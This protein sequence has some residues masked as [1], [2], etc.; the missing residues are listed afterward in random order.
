MSR[1][2]WFVLGMF[3]GFLGPHVIVFLTKVVKE[4]KMLPHEWKNPNSR[5]DKDEHAP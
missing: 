2:E 1:L 3:V 5:R 4:A